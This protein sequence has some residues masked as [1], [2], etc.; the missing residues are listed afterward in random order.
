MQRKRTD[1]QFQKVKKTESMLFGTVKGLNLCGRDLSIQY[2]NILIFEYLGNIRYGG[3]ILNS[4]FD[5][6]R[7]RA[8]K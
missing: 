7:K 5:L 1:T 6:A 8:S 4:N 3:L 2:K